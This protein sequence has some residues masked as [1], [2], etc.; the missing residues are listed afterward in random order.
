MK[1]LYLLVVT[2][3]ASAPRDLSLEGRP[4]LVAAPHALLLGSVQV[5]REDA[6]VALDEL[7]DLRVLPYEVLVVLALSSE[8]VGVL[9]EL[10]RAV[11]QIEVEVP[12]HDHVVQIESAERLG[13]IPDVTTATRQMHGPQRRRERTL[14]LAHLWGEKAEAPMLDG[15][16]WCF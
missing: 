1:F 5:L 9:L 7:L 11:A 16:C 3:S 15:F 6:A 2:A 12:A 8:L 10:V 4:H 13:E 14:Q